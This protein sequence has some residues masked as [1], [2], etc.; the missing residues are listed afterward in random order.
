MVDALIDSEEYQT[1]FGDDT[2]PFE[3]F[4]TAFD[5]NSRRVPSFRPTLDTASLPTGARFSTTARPEPSKKAELRTPGSTVQRNLQSRDSSANFGALPQNRTTGFQPVRLRAGVDS[6][7]GPTSQA[8]M[9][10]VLSGSKPEALSR[11]ESVG[12]VPLELSDNA[13]ESELQAVIE[14]VYRQLLNRMP[15]DAERCSEI[16]SQLR[17]G[18][19]TVSGFVAGV[20]ASETYQQRLTNLPP[21][22]AAAT[23]HLTLL[24]RSPKPEEISS[25]IRQRAEQGQRAATN[26]L[27]ESSDYNDCLL[28]TSPSPR[29]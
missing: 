16:E 24:G 19:L 29:D 23:A 9:K 3:R 7:D 26:A 17:N 11:R 22:L 21:L 28:Y 5:V 10:R 12:Y 2:V 13:T 1:A 27:L 14:A 15:F 25:F 6:N 18:S 8:T 20:A 4:I